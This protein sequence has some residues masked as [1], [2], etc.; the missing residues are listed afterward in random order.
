MGVGYEEAGKQKTN[1]QKERLILQQIGQYQHNP[2][3]RTP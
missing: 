3:D 2:F 1:K